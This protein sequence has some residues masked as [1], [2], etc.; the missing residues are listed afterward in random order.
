VIKEFKEFIM[1]GNI[2]DLAVAV[3]IGTAFA[4]VIKA[5]T[6]N[7]LMPIIGMIGGKRS[8]DEYLI[9]LNG[10]EIRY[11]S[12]ITA[13]VNFLIVAFALFLIVKAVNK[14]MSLRKKEKEAETELKI[15]EVELLEEIRDLLAERQKGGSILGGLGK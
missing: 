2:V 9:T 4:A 6:D 7:I 15:T 1:R 5:F 13:L 11:G 12:F 10:S 3:V 14:L 8:F